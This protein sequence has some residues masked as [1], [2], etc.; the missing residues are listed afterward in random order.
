MR[1]GACGILDHATC[2][3]SVTAVGMAF[4]LGRFRRILSFSETPII[5]Q[6]SRLPHIDST[7]GDASHVFKFWVL[8]NGTGA[9]V[10]MELAVDKAFNAVHMQIDE[11]RKIQPN[12]GAAIIPRQ[13][14]SGNVV[15]A[16]QKARVVSVSPELTAAHMRLCGGRQLEIQ[17][18]E[19]VRQDYLKEM[20]ELIE[21]NPGCPGCE[22]GA[23]TRKYQHLM[24]KLLG[25]TAT[26]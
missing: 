1:D 22:R 24:L 11:A 14:V 9:R 3:I 4:T 21:S 20:A 18:Q 15:V 5:I 26:F 6:M 8:D 13:P 25:S 17:E 7:G 19:F 16:G 23:V 10:P 2:Y 12:Y